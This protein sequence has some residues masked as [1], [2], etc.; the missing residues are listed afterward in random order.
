MAPY[1]PVPKATLAPDTLRG[2]LHVRAYPCSFASPSASG[3]EYAIARPVCCACE[4]RLAPG[5][6]LNEQEERSGANISANADMSMTVLTRA[7]FVT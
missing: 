7:S 1:T 3:V 5:Y 6:R 2:F 4:T